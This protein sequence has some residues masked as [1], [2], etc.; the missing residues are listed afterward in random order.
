MPRLRAMS[1]SNVFS[2]LKSWTPRKRLAITTQWTI[3]KSTAFLSPI[4][5]S[6]IQVMVPSSDLSVTKV[7]SISFAFYRGYKKA[8]ARSRLKRV[9]KL[10]TARDASDSMLIIQG[11][12]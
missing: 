4:F 12:T 3:P 6:I 2:N 1:C 10:A 11:P 9:W 5:F 7:G 8:S